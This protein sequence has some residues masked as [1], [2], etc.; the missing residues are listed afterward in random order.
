MVPRA[1]IVASEAETP[2]DEALEMLSKRPHSR[3]PVYRES[4]DDVVGLLHIKDVLARMATKE[5]FRLQEIL[6]DVLIVAPSLP[7]LDLVREMRE[8]RQPLALGIDEFGGL[9]GQRSWVE[10]VVG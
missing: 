3:V 6:R 8:N 10:G 9:G 2:P 5:P 7:V 1:E 4:L